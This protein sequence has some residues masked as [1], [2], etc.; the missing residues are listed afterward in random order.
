MTAKDLE[1]EYLLKSEVEVLFFLIWGSNQFMHF[2]LSYI[3][4]SKNY[5]NCI[6]NQ[7]ENQF[8]SVK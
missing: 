8:I 1:I 4:Y 3:N 6:K 7:R 2:F 5:L